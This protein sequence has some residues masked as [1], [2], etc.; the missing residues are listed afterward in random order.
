MFVVSGSFDKQ[1]RVWMIGHHD[2]NHSLC[3]VF[4]LYDGIYEWRDLVKINVDGWI[5]GPEGKLL[6][7]IPGYYHALFYSPRNALVIPRG[8]PELDLSMMV[9]GDI[10]Q[11]CYIGM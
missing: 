7:W 5:I 8:G 4:K 11:E 2:I 1:I 10:W 9:H 3:N 6:L